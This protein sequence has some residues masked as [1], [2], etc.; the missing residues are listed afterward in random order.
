MSLLIP[1][2]EYGEFTLVGDTHTTT[3]IDGIAD[4]SR[5]AIGMYVSGSGVQANTTVTAKT[6]NSVTLSLAT[7]STLSDIDINFYKRYDFDYPTSNDSEEGFDPKEKIDTSLSG[8][9]QVL[10]SY[11]EATRNVTIGFATSTQKETLRSDF[12]L[13]WAV[14]GNSFRYYPDK[15]ESTYYDYEL[16]SY[17]LKPKRQIKKHPSFLFELNFTFSRTVTD[18]EMEY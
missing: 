15:D 7:I 4:T 6:A 10:L 2:L 14:K 9:N 11:V 5:V 8:E 13:K 12:Y 1:R 3:T 18:L 17:N 16:K